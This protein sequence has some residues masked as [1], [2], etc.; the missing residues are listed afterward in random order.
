MLVFGDKA[1][2]RQTDA[3]IAAIEKVWSNAAGASGLDRHALLTSAFIGMA[4]LVQGLGDAAFDTAGFD[5]LDPATEAA[6]RLLEAMA[7][8]VRRSWDSGFE[9]RAEANTGAAISESFR[10]L[11]QAL[12]PAA[13][14]CKQA[15]GYAFYALFP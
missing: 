2:T 13:V 14:T 8:E 5:E 10:R 15:E 9:E 6:M 7:R 12:L 1:S 4:E 3:A 11:Y